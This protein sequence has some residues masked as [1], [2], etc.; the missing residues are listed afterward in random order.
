MLRISSSLPRALAALTMIAV[1][2]SAAWAQQPPTVRA[3]RLDD[4]VLTTVTAGR[5]E[6][7]AISGSKA[8]VGVVGANVDHEFAGDA[9]GLGHTPDDE[10]HD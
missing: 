4:Y 5:P 1:L 8:L 6:P 10:L 9:V 2:G 7:Q 3:G